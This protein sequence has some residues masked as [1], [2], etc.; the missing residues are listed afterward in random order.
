M[1]KANKTRTRR[2][3]ATPTKASVGPSTRHQGLILRARMNVDVPIP[4]IAPLKYLGRYWSYVLTN[5]LRLTDES[6]TDIQR[7][8]LDDLQ[9]LGVSKEQIRMLAGMN[10]L[11][12]SMPYISEQEGWEYRTFPW[13]G[14]LNLVTKPYRKSDQ[15]LAIVRHLRQTV[16]LPA[17]EKPKKL[18]IVTSAPGALKLRF[19]FGP[20]C[21]LV[22]RAF[23]GVFEDENIKTLEN[24]SYV[25]LESFIV[26]FKPDIIHLSGV[27]SHQKAGMLGELEDASQHDAFVLRCDDGSPYDMAEAERMARA[28]T[29]GQ[30]YS[31]W[32]VSYNCY[33]SGARLAALAVATGARSAIGFQDT[34]DDAI[35]E[36]VFCNIYTIWN[37]LGWDRLAEALALTQQNVIAP[38]N[39]RD[40]G[41]V[42]LWS[43]TSLVETSDDSILYWTKLAN[44]ATRSSRSWQKALIEEFGVSRLSAGPP[45]QPSPS[46][47]PPAGTMP[48][49]VPPPQTTPPAPVVTEADIQIQ[50]RP[51]K[52][53]NYSLLHN[54][55]SIFER[56]QLLA[57]PASLPIDLDIS[58]NLCCGE[59]SFPAQLR[60]KVLESPANFREDIYLPLLAPMLRGRR[61]GISSTLAVE[62][63]VRTGLIFAEVY[64]IRLLPADEWTD[65]DEDRRWLPSFILPRDPAVQQVIEAAQRYL[66]SLADD[67]SAGFDGYQRV[68]AVDDPDGIVD[69]Q[70]RALW[71]ALL[72]EH[73][74]SYINPPPTYT[75]AAQRI[76]T[77]SQILEE[78]RGT[79][80]DL[81]LLFA[82]SLEYL[83]LMPV[84]FL[85]HGHAFPGYWRSPAARDTFRGF[86]N[87]G[88]SL[89]EEVTTQTASS[90]RTLQEGWMITSSEGLAEISRAIQ[91]GGLVPI[92]TTEI[93]RSGSF[94]SALDIG[95]K[96]LITQWSFDAMVDIQTARDYLVTPLP[97]FNRDI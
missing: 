37:Q 73:P 31:P 54:R 32:L 56:F 41:D 15:T 14:M 96:N 72:Y 8:A 11:E 65:S 77:P 24:P 29:G 75:P 7:R 91:S 26:E 67:R 2:A 80:L 35:A 57:P 74:S 39:P 78:R 58:I 12:I 84:M 86:G 21:D 95:M 69:L 17:S 62:I 42:V 46:V 10:I 9:E 3:T 30:T 88:H 13:E 40:R 55:R 59:Q 82:A 47:V 97:L 36:Q 1:P 20:E 50:V 27:D 23:A 81:A 76:R 18:L 6:R 38:A 49:R 43:E 68:T 70:V 48:P 60:R 44:E 71:S 61:E 19:D 25:T 53:L 93:T 94:V 64:P 33:N 92:E 90:S 16:Q 22:R 51:V 4:N 85:I 5:R 34:I 63:R 79:C 89:R 66:R 83:G 45:S 52:N 28:L 87:V